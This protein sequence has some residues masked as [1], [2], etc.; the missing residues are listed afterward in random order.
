MAD[1]WRRGLVGVES[2]F[3]V[4]VCVSATH[5]LDA[6]VKRLVEA[7]GRGGGCGAGRASSRAEAEWDV[8]R[9]GGEPLAEAE[10]MRGSTRGGEE[11][12]R[13]VAMGVSLPS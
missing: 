13:A 1:A 5:L 3:E 4:G 9:V 10:G 2:G 6:E 12:L 8:G 7:A 11:R